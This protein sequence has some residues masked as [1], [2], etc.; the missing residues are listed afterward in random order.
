M[1]TFSLSAAIRDISSFI[2]VQKVIPLLLLDAPSYGLAQPA[3]LASRLPRACD[4][5]LT[6]L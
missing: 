2:E 3:G 1:S 4:D 5:F 6:A